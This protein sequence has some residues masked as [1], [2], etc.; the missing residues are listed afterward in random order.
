MLPEDNQENDYEYGHLETPTNPH[1]PH[2]DI[3][4]MLL[5]SGIFII[6]ILAGIGCIAAGI[7]LLVTNQGGRGLSKVTTVGGSFDGPAE[8]LLIVV[9]GV[10][11]FY[12]VRH[13]K[14]KF[15]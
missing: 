2:F 5:H 12:T 9:G 11:L 7:Y 3:I 8:C 13:Y 1:K 15:K 6:F 14:V 4:K 10:L